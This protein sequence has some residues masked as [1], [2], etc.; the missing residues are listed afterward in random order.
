MI[1]NDS[2]KEPASGHSK[3]SIRQMAFIGVI[4]AAIC[5]L[6]P[7]S[8]PIGPV[9]ISLTNLVLYIALYVI[10]TK[11]TLISYAIYLLIGLVGL[12]VFSGFTGGFAKLAG[13]TGGYLIG[14]LPMV[15][16]A[17]MIISKSKGKKYIDFLGMLA[18]TCVCYALGTIWLSVST[19]MSFNAAL[20]A[21]VIPFIP[22]DV[23]KM[24]IA[25]LL[26]SKLKKQLSKFTL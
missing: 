25:M 5:I 9:P 10:G 13:P 15:L 18:A 2:V 16:I 23:I 12:P 8:I 17:G 7:L 6:A 11:N 4:T 20:L 3:L 1:S 19:G 22:G 21:G 26:G 24:I 14:F